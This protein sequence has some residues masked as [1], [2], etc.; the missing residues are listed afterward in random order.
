M[1]NNFN[2][3]SQPTTTARE[4]ANELSTFLASLRAS[5]EKL[6]E[7]L[8]KIRHSRE[9]IQEEYFATAR[10]FVSATIPELNSEKID[11][12]SEIASHVAELG[13]QSL[14]FY[15]QKLLDAREAALGLINKTSA[16]TIDVEGFQQKLDNIEDTLDVAKNISRDCEAAVRT[17]QNALK[18]WQNSA[19][20]GFVNLND[21]ITK[22]GALGLSPENRKYYEPSNIFTAAYRYI[23]RDDAYRAVRDALVN[24]G[25]SLKGKDVFADFAS[26]SKKT[27][28][29]QANLTAASKKFDAANLDCEKIAQT[30]KTLSVTGESLKTDEQILKLVQ[31]KVVSYLSNNEFSKAVADAFGEDF[32]RNISL[33]SAKLA[34]LQKLEEG[35]EAKMQSLSKTISAVSAQYNKANRATPYAKANVDL[36]ALKR[37][38]AAYSDHY[39]KYA[40]ATHES[41]NRT[42]SYSPPPS[43]VYV[44]NSPSFF[45]TIL[46]MDILSS[47]H[48]DHD[49]Y[50]VTNINNFDVAP[51]AGYSADL[52]GIDRGN[53]RDFGLPTTNF[54]FET[55]AAV[56]TSNFDFD[57]REPAPTPTPSYTPSRND[58]FDF[59]SSSGSSS[60]NFDFPSRNDSPSFG[61]GGR[62]NS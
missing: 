59:P 62:D 41:W 60:S 47:H 14:R 12:I 35:A 34:T 9:E 43:V 52:F 5:G 48:H 42:T 46:I 39:K 1:Y 2:N 49:R 58:D 33:M 20:Y 23:A 8:K 11:E 30:I 22:E 15:R 55:P 24:Y 26:W 18:V 54:D 21:R 29:L 7:E 32:P 37:N 44:D 3:S 50:N 45:E 36:D 56:S 40:D 28:T 31:D 61:G 19:E 27:E 10:S 6:E 17:E 13:G 57:I 51:T 38:N 4:L 53:A 16:E 25:H